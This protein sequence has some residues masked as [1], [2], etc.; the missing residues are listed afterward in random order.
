MNHSS[1]DLSA[2]HKLT[3]SELDVSN[4]YIVLINREI[5]NMIITDNLLNFKKTIGSQKTKN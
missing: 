4:K 5:E 2:N 3:I 1:S